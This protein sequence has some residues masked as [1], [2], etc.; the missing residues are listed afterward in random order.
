M[1]VGR[2]AST[3]PAVGCTLR[4]QEWALDYRYASNEELDP[5]LKCYAQSYSLENCVNLRSI[6]G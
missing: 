2:S 3:G 6:I 1:G 4:L 5:L